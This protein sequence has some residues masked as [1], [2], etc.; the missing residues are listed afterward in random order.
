MPRRHNSRLR[1]DALYRWKAT[2]HSAFILL[3]V[4]QSDFDAK[5]LSSLLAAWYGIL[6]LIETDS[7]R[8]LLFFPMQNTAKF[9]PLCLHWE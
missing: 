7:H 9:Y 6:V 1:Q 3:Y 2:M 4:S 8:H 5:G